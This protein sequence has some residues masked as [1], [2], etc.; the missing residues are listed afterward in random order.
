ML[1]FVTH[2]LYCLMVD[3]NVN[4]HV[5]SSDIHM[6]SADCTIP[7]KSTS[8]Q[9]MGLRGRVRGPCMSGLS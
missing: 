7:A 1:Q 5:S 8:P 9:R 4:I 2:G 3:L 6:G